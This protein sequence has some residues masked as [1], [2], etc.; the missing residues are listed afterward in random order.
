MI[1]PTKAAPI[2]IVNEIL[3]PRILE[4]FNKVP[5]SIQTGGNKRSKSC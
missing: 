4:R 1:I 5:T 3:V 2:P